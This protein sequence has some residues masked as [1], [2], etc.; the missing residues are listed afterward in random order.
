MG[1]KSSKEKTDVP[2]ANPSKANKA[3]SQKVDKGGKRPAVVSNSPKKSASEIISSHINSIVALFIKSERLQEF[4]G[5]EGVLL[6]AL[7]KNKANLKP[8][9]TLRLIQTLIQNNPDEKE[10]GK[11]FTALQKKVQEVLENKSYPVSDPAVA[12]FNMLLTG[13]KVVRI[14]AFRTEKNLHST[15]IALLETDI[16][17]IA[18]TEIEMILIDGLSQDLIKAGKVTV[19]ESEDINSQEVLKRCLQFVKSSNPKDFVP[20]A[21]KL[22]RFYQKMEQLLYEDGETDLPAMKEFV[23]VIQ[24]EL[25]K[26]LKDKYFSTDL[27]RPIRNKT[28][29]YEMNNF[30][31]FL[32]LSFG[33]INY[34]TC[35]LLPRVKVIT[36][37]VH[38][39]QE[40]NFQMIE[41]VSAISL[42]KEG[43]ESTNRL[44]TNAKVGVLAQKLNAAQSTHVRHD[45]INDF[46]SVVVHQ[47]NERLY[48]ALKDDSFLND[49]ADKGNLKDIKIYFLKDTERITDDEGL[50]IVFM[51]RMKVDSVKNPSYFF[52]AKEGDT[53]QSLKDFIKNS[54]PMISTDK[55]F[56]EMIKKLYFGRRL[57]TSKKERKERLTFCQKLL[58]KQ[59][60]TPLK[61]LIEAVKPLDEKRGTDSPK[62]IDLI[63]SVD[64]NSKKYEFL[65]QNLSDSRSPKPVYLKP[66]LSDL[67]S[68]L[69]KIDDADLNEDEIRD[70]FPMYLYVS[71]ESIPNL[72]DVPSEMKLSNFT[73]QIQNFGL[74]IN[75]AYRATGFVAQKQNGEFYNIYTSKDNKEEVFAYS[76][77]NKKVVSS[78]SKLNPNQ[79]KGVY[80]ERKELDA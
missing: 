7:L 53:L 56:E 72:C 74:E 30:R 59:F 4:L 19:G 70:N 14:D 48:Y 42:N 52:L 33:Y 58:G 34:S 38:T 43:I 80:F 10:G 77:D 2:V 66:L 28:A 36:A 27:I 63:V 25:N 78:I 12:I 18:D 22:P 73:E 23:Q 35:G 29:M 50:K 15:L 57:L 61:D 24:C 40:I 45:L 49:E 32:N 1:G 9:E 5:P 44:F 41:L 21:T 60:N 54:F 3:T 11:I 8:L 16:S 31:C 6:E 20:M 17:K 13:V 68:E 75:P 37:Q 55:T 76:A 69:N 39:P 64:L 67:S 62:M 51:P 71:L 47:K 26:E 79:L 65:P 46:D